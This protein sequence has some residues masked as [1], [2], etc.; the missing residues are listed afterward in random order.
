MR[1]HRFESA[2]W[3]CSRLSCPTTRV[4]SDL[5]CVTPFV[6]EQF[7]GLDGL[8]MESNYDLDMLVRGRYPER[9]KRRIASDLG[10]LSNEQAALF[11]DVVAH[12]DLQVVVGH[13]SQENN[14]P[15]LLEETF[16]PYRE[17]VADLCIATQDRGADWQAVRAMSEADEPDHGGLAWTLTSP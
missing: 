9:V 4:I 5:G 11:L 17:R 8:L 13:V 12:A 15:D 14:H 3:R 1:T 2:P 7:R 10:H 16:A 6:V